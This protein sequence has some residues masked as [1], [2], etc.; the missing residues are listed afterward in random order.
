MVAAWIGLI[1]GLS[2]RENGASSSPSPS[3]RCG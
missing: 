2:V 1:V 3:N